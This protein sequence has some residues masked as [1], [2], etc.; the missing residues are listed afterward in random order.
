MSGGSGV[1]PQAPDDVSSLHMSRAG[2]PGI[3]GMDRTSRRTVAAESEGDRTRPAA[4]PIPAGLGMVA[5]AVAGIIAGTVMFL[6]LAA[7]LA[8]SRGFW[9]PLHAVQALISGRRVLPESRGPLRGTSPADFVVAPLLFLLPALAVGLAVAWWLGRRTPGR[10][11][12][13][14][15][16]RVAAVAAVPT[17]VLFGL[18]VGVLGFRE[19]ADS[20]QRISSGV[21]VRRVGLAAWI[22]AHVVYVAVLAAVLGPVQRIALGLR[23]RR[24]RRRPLREASDD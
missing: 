7:F 14:S 18:L 20:V 10:T 13:E 21:G 8:R 22:V 5:G 2:R 12:Q 19:A 3:V 16:W 23:A 24:G 9:Y 1:V 15:L 6:V 17:A 11:T 4:A